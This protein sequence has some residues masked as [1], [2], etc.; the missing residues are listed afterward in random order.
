MCPNIEKKESK[1]QDASLS[2]TTTHEC[3][4]HFGV[5]KTFHK[6]SPSHEKVFPL[7]FSPP[8]E[9]LD[10]CSSE[11]IYISLVKRER[12]KDEAVNDVENGETIE[13]I[14]ERR[15]REPRDI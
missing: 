8:S 12:A 14:G 7:S 10:E 5:N 11:K 6:E 13:S 2:Q 3:S 1:A 4:T 9:S 15:E